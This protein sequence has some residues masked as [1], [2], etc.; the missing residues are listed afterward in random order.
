MENGNEREK[1]PNGQNGELYEDAD[2]GGAV[3]AVN[4]MHRVSGEKRIGFRMVI[5][6]F[7]CALVIAAA[8]IFV[9]G[10]IRYNQ[11]QAEKEELQEKLKELESK[12]EKLQYELDSPIDYDYIVRRAHELGMHFPDEE[13]YYKGN[14]N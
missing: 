2:V 12:N 9:S 13:V 8:C 10:I 7:L 1:E 11:L 14:G 6:F 3:K 5:L 4:P